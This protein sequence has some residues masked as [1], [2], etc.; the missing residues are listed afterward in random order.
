MQFVL[1]RLFPCACIAVL[2]FFRTQIQHTAMGNFMYKYCH[3]M[4]SPFPRGRYSVLA[5]EKDEEQAEEVP[6]CLLWRIPIPLLGMHLAY[7]VCTEKGCCFGLLLAFFPL[8]FGEVDTVTECSQWTPT[9]LSRG[10][11]PACPSRN[12]VLYCQFVFPFFPALR[13]GDRGCTLHPAQPNGILL[14]P[15]FR[16]L[17]SFLASTLSHTPMQIDSVHEWSLQIPSRGWGI[18]R[19]AYCPRQRGPLLL[20]FTFGF[21]SPLFRDADRALEWSQWTPITL[22]KGTPAACLNPVLY[23]HFAFAF[24]W[25]RL[26]GCP[27]GRSGYPSRGLGCTSRMPTRS[28]WGRGTSTAYRG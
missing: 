17:F 25:G 15:S 28:E 1:K 3:D 22:N 13:P 12:P 14:W 2:L 4:V 9:T 19:H 26:T 5:K 7:K 24:L 18:T 21:S 27:S 20:P 10:T 6:K 16:L 8:F 23:W 11:P